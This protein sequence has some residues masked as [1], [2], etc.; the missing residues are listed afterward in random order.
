MLFRSKRD[1]SILAEQ[2][3]LF[4]ERV[5]QTYLYFLN[6]DSI[7]N[8]ISSIDLQDTVQP[9]VKESLSDVEKVDS[10]IEDV[11]CELPKSLN[12]MP[13]EKLNNT[14]NSVRLNDIND[15]VAQENIADNFAIKSTN[16]QIKNIDEIKNQKIISR[17]KSHNKIEDDDEYIKLFYEIIGGKF[18]QRLMSDNGSENDIISDADLILN[19]SK[20]VIRKIA[21]DMNIDDIYDN[22]VIA[23]LNE[24]I[25]PVDEILRMNT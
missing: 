6:H 10:L 20:D 4:L 3:V 23:K 22:R 17:R 5:G 1:L 12:S 7:E 24:K 15:I 19:A 13:V 11:I 14:S 18:Q 25:F 2:N 16:Y 21:S 8:D 9:I